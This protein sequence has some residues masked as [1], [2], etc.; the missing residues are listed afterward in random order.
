MCLKQEKI[1]FF[2]P[3][4]WLCSFVW[5]LYT[6][7]IKSHNVNELIVL[8]IAI[9]NFDSATLLFLI[10]LQLEY[11]QPYN[12]QLQK[13]QI[14]LY[15]TCNILEVT[16]VWN[17]LSFGK[18]KHYALNIYF[19]EDNF[20]LKVDFFLKDYIPYLNIKWKKSFPPRREVN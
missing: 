1:N 12:F 17:Y 8:I 20:I 6:P 13:L 16:L 2:L 18:Y 19:K 3:I 15:N 14:R 5:I 4:Y 9:K 11:L 10:I 7:A